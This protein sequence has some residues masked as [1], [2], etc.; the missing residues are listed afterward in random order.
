MI[1]ILIVYWNSCF[2]LHYF[3]LWHPNLILQL[4]IY[5]YIYGVMQSC[6]SERSLWALLSLKDLQTL[7]LLQ[8][9]IASLLRCA[10][11]HRRRC[12]FHGFDLTKLHTLAHKISTART[13]AGWRTPIGCYI[14]L[15]SDPLD[16]KFQ[17]KSW[18]LSPLLV[19]LIN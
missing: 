10:L 8:L 11:H 13:P 14:S 7:S 1:F 18:G 4:Y 2:V 5:I 17:F 6:R 19:H 15:W 12:L 16:K 3:I 9:C